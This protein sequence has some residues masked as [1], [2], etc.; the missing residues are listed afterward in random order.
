MLDERRVCVSRIAVNVL[1][2]REVIETVARAGIV[3]SY[4]SSCGAGSGA[5]DGSERYVLLWWWKAA[6]AFEVGTVE[7]ASEFTWNKRGVMQ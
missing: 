2:R 3:P 1:R 7:L 5:A 4:D 6:A